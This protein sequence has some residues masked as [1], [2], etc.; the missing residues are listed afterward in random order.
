MDDYFIYNHINMDPLDMLKT[1]FVSNCGNYY[2][3]G[4]PIRLKK[5]GAT[6]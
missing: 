3:N 5:V 1:M 6:Y 2:Y 4:M